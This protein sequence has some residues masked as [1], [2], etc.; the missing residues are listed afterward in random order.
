MSGEVLEALHTRH[1]AAAAAAAGGISVAGV[2]L[3]GGDRGPN[4]SNQG[5]VVTCLLEEPGLP[6]FITA[7]AG[8]GAAATNGGGRAGPEEVLSW[9]DGRDWSEGVPVPQQLL[10]DCPPEVFAFLQE[11]TSAL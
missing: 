8:G 3:G 5:L 11:R 4:L 10:V 1:A 2:T 9:L 6:P 7:A